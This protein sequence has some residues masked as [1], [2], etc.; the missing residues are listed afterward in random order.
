MPKMVEPAAVRRFLLNVDFP[1]TK[2]EIVR[3]AERQKADDDV[4]FTLEQLPER[5]YRSPGE[6]TTALGAP[7]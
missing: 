7:E 1:A 6:V 3:A 5:E 4:L 2:G